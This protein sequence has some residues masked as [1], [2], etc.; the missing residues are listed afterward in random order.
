MIAAAWVCLLAP[1][2]A[3]V[4]ITLGGNRLSRRAAGYIATLSVAVSSSPQRSRSSQCSGERAGAAL[5]ALDRLDL[6]LGRQL[7]RRPERPRRPALDLH[8]AD[9]LRRRRAHRRLLDRLHG[10]R[11]RG[12]A[13]LRLHGALRLLDAA[14]RPGREPADA[15]R[16]LGPRRALLVPADRLPPRAAERGRGREEGLH[17]E[18]GRRRDDGARPLPAHPADR[19]ARVRLARSSGRAAQRARGP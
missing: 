19:L 6:A 9:R 18:R 8:D 3:A 16:R 5:A 10:R 7:R 4:A 11:R 12:A 1:L 13:L 2:A 15:A 17:H 14:A